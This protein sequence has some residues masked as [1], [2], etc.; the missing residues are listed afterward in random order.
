MIKY[1]L[2]QNVVKALTSRKPNRNV[3]AWLDSVEDQALALSVMTLM[4][5]EKGIEMER[6]K[7]TGDTLAREKRA[8]SIKAGEDA[9]TNLR[10]DYGD[11]ILALDDECALELGRLIAQKNKNN[12]D[13][14][15][16]ATAKRHK[17]ILV[18]RNIGD[19]TGRGV[20]L[21]DPFVAEPTVTR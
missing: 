21:L 4:E 3:D 12:F 19:L 13:L 14:A 16:A 9:L 6:Q 1:L 20:D 18:T 2:D 11:R 10:A 17:L 8:K 7:K 15:Y 5:S